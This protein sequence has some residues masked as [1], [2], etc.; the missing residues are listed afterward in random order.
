MM[1]CWIIGNMLIEEKCIALGLIIMCVVIVL[2]CLDHMSERIGLFVFFISIF[3][4]LIVGAIIQPFSG[5]ETFDSSEYIKASNCLYITCISLM[6]GCLFARKNYRIKY[7]NQHFLT[8]KCFNDNMYNIETIQT[9]AFVLFIVSAG[10]S[11]AT[12]FQRMMYA[13]TNGYMTLYGEYSSSSLAK[14]LHIVCM[15]SL[16]IGLAAKPT[17][18]QMKIYI[19]IGLVNPLMQLIEGGRSNFVA[20]ILFMATFLFNKQYFTKNSKI[21]NEVKNEKRNIK[22]LIVVG[23]VALLVIVPIMYLIGFSRM[24]YDIKKGSSIFALIGA[25]FK[26]QGRSFELIEYAEKYKGELPGINYTFGALIDKINGNI[27]QNYTAEYALNR[28][29]FGAIIIYLVKPYNFITLKNGM[30]SSY[31]AELYYD[32]NYIGVFIANVFLGMLLERL[33]RHSSESVLQRSMMFLL[34]YYMLIMPRGPFMNPI[35]QLIS[36]S[37][38]ITYL[39]VMIMAK[40]KSR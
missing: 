39:I 4:F 36:F 37:T 14:R 40:K 7:G 34:F 17:L 15:A 29:D 1:V 30:G 20:Y 10:I 21:I 22:R 32:F 12:E 27:Y 23:I 33:S 28:N 18:K 9:V 25:F 26:G 8:A 38:I 2:F 13:L 19:F 35:Q 6:L 16:F 5:N 24:G 3:T 11:L 31:I